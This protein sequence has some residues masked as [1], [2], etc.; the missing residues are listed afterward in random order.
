MHKMVD[1]CYCLDQ[2]VGPV[3]DGHTIS[4]FLQRPHRLSEGRGKLT[5]PPPPTAFSITC[6]RMAFSLRFG[7]ARMAT[8][9]PIILTV[10][11]PAN[12]LPLLRPLLT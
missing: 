10:L 12:D 9:L 8:Y 5:P 6:K 11:A 1:N 7:L 3:S 2:C 4:A